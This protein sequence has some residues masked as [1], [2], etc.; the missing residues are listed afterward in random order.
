ML[1]QASAPQWKTALEHIICRTEPGKKHIAQLMQRF[2]HSER[3]EQL[4]AELCK[5]AAQV[6]AAVQQKSDRR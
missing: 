1:Y 6:L 2:P 5:G 4:E 3:T